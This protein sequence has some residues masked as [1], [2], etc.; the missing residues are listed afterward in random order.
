MKTTKRI[1]S[2]LLILAMLLSTLTCLTFAAQK[3]TGTRHELCTSLSTQANTYYG[4][5]NF[6]YE[7]YAALQGGNESC[8]D[9]VDSELF[10]ALSELMTDTM[11]DSVSYSNLTNYWPDTD[12]ESDT[13]EAT[14]F[15]SDETSGS[16]NREHVWPKS[17]ASFLKKDGGCDIHHL[18]P[19]NSNINSTRSNY[20]MGEVQEK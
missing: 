17:R 1:V 15:Y 4:A 12:R 5:N 7:D 11:T 16:Y 9:T 2:V 13:S 18:R 14:L 20:T 6:T 3:N 8:L 19:T 10:K